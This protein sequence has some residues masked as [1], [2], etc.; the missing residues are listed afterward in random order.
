MDFEAIEN[1]LIKELKPSRFNHTKGVMYTA[2]C[3]A[4]KYDYDINR[5]MLAGL[6][7]DCTK[8][9]S[10]EE[11]I[12]ICHE[13]KIEISNSE[14]RNPYLLHQKTGAYYAKTKYEILDEEII[15]AISVHTT[16]CTNMNLLDKIIFIADFIEPGRNKA[17][18]LN[19]LRQMAFTDIDKCLVMVLKSTLDYLKSTGNE[20]EPTTQMVYDF[21]CQ[22]ERD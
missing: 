11:Q 4:M 15:H 14:L 2:A 17:K 10:D 5:A 9:L 18:D 7:H 8:C 19:I 16:G 13:N 22:N 12:K 6:L 20:I 21:Y 1:Q 3:M